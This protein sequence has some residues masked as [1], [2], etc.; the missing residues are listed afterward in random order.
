MVQDKVIVIDF[1]MNN[2]L[3]EKRKEHTNRS[4]SDSQVLTNAIVLYY[5]SQR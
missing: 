1:L 3:K 2:L 4:F 5:I